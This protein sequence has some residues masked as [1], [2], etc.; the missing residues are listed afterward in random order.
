VEPALFGT[1]PAVR[2]HAYSV[3]LLLLV[4]AWCSVKMTVMLSCRPAEPAPDSWLPSTGM[5][6]ELLHQ[7]RVNVQVSPY[8]QLVAWVVQTPTRGWLRGLV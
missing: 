8:H 2:I 7:V 3:L 1:L 5:N 4:W 6:T